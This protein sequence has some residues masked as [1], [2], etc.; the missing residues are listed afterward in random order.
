MENTERAESRALAESFANRKSLVRESSAVKGTSPGRSVTIFGV[1]HASAAASRVAD[2][3]HNGA[4]AAR[5]ST[6]QGARRIRGDVR[7]RVKNLNCAGAQGP[8]VGIW[9]WTIAN[10]RMNAILTV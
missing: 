9:K 6:S 8:R 7:E 10:A 2:R 3:D 5:S 1:N 4:A